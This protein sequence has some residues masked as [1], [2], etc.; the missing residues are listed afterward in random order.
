M[1]HNLKEKSL[2]PR[3]H[4]I[5]RERVCNLLFILSYHYYTGSHLEVDE[6]DAPYNTTVVISHLTTAS[7]SIVFHDSTR[8][9]PKHLGH[10]LENDAGS[11]LVDVDTAT[12]STMV[13]MISPYSN[14]DPF[15][16]PKTRTRLISKNLGHC[17][18]CHN[19]SHSENRDKPTSSKLFRMSSRQNMPRNLN[20]YDKYI[21]KDRKRHSYT[22]ALRALFEGRDNNPAHE[23]FFNSLI[24]GLKK[25]NQCLDR[26]SVHD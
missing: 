24:S 26:M 13:E 1:H 8:L 15:T 9:S 2:H 17:L 19:G 20:F 12:S 22:I 6:T 14:V 25:K 4:L 7:S 10:C 18:E 21:R 16:A 5:H 11:Q 23:K 3:D